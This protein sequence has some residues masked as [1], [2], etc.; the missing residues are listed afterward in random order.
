LKTTPFLLAGGLLLIGFAVLVKPACL[1]TDAGDRLMVLWRGQTGSIRF[2][3]SV[4]GRPV[5]IDFE[6]GRLFR[7]FAVATDP[8][9]EA[10]YT[11]GVYALEP[12]LAAESTR[13]LHFCSS[14]GMELRFGFY[15][16]PLQGG[17]LEATLL[18]TR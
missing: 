13:R 9:T 18:W 10:Y 11:H 5:V 1:R 6:I 15:D 14:T 17:C 2:T 16:I 7:H 4:T 8:T 12:A 3:N